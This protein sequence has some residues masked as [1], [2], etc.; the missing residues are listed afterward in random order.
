MEES[1]PEN[2]AEEYGVTIVSEDAR[3]WYRVLQFFRDL[4]YQVI[5]WPILSAVFVAFIEFRAPG[6]IG[7]WPEI[8]GL[9][10]TLSVLGIFIIVGY[11]CTLLVKSGG[12]RA[13]LNFFGLIL[14]AVSVAFAM[15]YWDIKLPG[16]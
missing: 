10:I 3:L 4:F 14:L 12:L 8:L 11:N 9:Y 6:K 7:G 1:S 5:F 13:T 16:I 15:V 2:P